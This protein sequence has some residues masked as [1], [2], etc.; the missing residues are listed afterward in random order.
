[1]FR[2]LRV[3]VLVENSV[4]SKKAVAIMISESLSGPSTGGVFGLV[5]NN[6]ISGLRLTDQ[7]P[8]SDS[9]VYRIGSEFLF[10][11]FDPKS[12]RVRQV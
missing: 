3:D 11:Y 9:V 4:S 8:V 2:N 6:V 1:M 10:I 12:W 7:V 5:L